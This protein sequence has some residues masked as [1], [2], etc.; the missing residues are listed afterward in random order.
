MWDS[1]STAARES[2]WRLASVRDELEK[3]D[4]ALKH[5]WENASNADFPQTSAHYGNIHATVVYFSER[6]RSAAIRNP[7]VKQ[8]MSYFVF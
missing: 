6:K 7:A 1:V 5:F 3:C 4:T 8:H 2:C